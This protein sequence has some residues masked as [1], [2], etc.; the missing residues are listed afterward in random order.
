MFL[1]FLIQVRARLRHSLQ[2]AEQIAVYRLPQ[3]LHG[4]TYPISRT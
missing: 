3:Q 2:G 4:E 1:P